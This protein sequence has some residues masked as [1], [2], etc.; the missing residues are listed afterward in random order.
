MSPSRPFILRPVATSLL[1]AGILLVGA[2]A[3]RQLPVSALPQVDYP[4]IQVVTFYP[5]ASPDVMASSVTAPLERQFGQVPG[6]N[7]MTSTSSSGASVITL[8][9]TLDLNID[10]AEQQVQAAINAAGTFLP[11]DLPNPPIYSKTNPADAPILTLALTSS[12]MPL[13][14]V[15]DLADTRLAQKIS[16]LSGVGLVSIS[17][18]QKPAVRIQANPMTLSS[19]KLNLEDLRLAIA[20]ANVNQ[21]K[22]N[23]DGP[24]NSY[25][26]GA[27]D[28]LLSSD[29]YRPLLIA[30]RNGAPVTLSDVATVI[31]SAENIKQAAWMNDAPAVILNIQ[32]QPGANIIEVVD[33]VKRLLPQLRASLPSS[34]DVATLTDRT[35]TIRASV[36]DVQFELMLTVALVVMVIFLFLR[37]LSAT[38]IPSVAVPL[39]LVGTFGAMYLLGYSLNN[40]TLMALTISTGFVVDDA[41]VMIENIARFIEA[42][43][44]PLQA[45][46]KGAEQIGF[47]ILSL[48]VSLIAVLIPLLFMGDIVGRLF[49][50]F[51]ITLSVTIL[52]SAAVSLTLTPMMCARL[53]HHKPESEQGRFY[54]ASEHMFQRIIAFYGRTLQVVLRHQPITLLVAVATLAATFLLY[55][56]IPKGFFPVQDTGVIL[57]V[58][59]APQTVS[60]AAM[61]QRQQS[62]AKMILQDPAVESLSSF[63]GID[64]TNTTVNSGRLQINLKPLEERKIS[65]SDVIRR[66]QPQL[67]KVDG[68]QLFM[69]PV[70][71][72]TVEDRVSRTQFQFSLEDPDPKE[73]DTW[74]PRFISKLQTLP[75]LRDVA[76]D[77]QNGGLQ[78]LLVIDRDT[79]SRFGITPQMIDDTLYDAFGQRQVSIMFT[80][81]NQYRV[82][83]EIKPDFQRNPDELKNIYIRSAQGGEVPLSAFTHF[84]PSNGPLVVNH[85]GQFPVVTASF[86]LASSASLGDAV[87]AV[88]KA[89]KELGLPASIATSFQGTAAAFQ[90]SLAN[91]PILILAAVITVYIVLGVLYESYIHPLTILSTLP[92]AGVGALL[93]LMLCR[94]DFSVIALIGIILLIGIVEKNAIMMIDFALDLERKEGYRP[95]DA[96]FQACLLRF[97]P[98]IMTTL[99]AMLGGV[100]LALGTGVGAELRRPL[101]IAIV[102]GLIFS[103]LLTLYTTPVIYLAFDRMARRV[104]GHRA[105]GS[106]LPVEET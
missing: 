5:G 17:G 66:L 14:K 37:T 24:L 98:I 34:I 18:G 50:E 86:N 90:A 31:D 88:N 51:A 65:A 45:A 33:R 76:S 67:A 92:S 39:S 52:I 35:I 44:P 16:Q 54:R 72:L 2:V 13:S 91:E 57:G 78:A 27:N 49:R 38:V 41:I 28:Q 87:D 32:R 71:D 1:M 69:Q 58:S 81:L 59:E 82:V 11:R 42:G 10:V 60:F 96:I 30:Y 23:F 48:T 53:L 80:Q 79:A 3:Y 106:D 94:Q 100:P 93:A 20:A 89:K 63:I 105:S 104:T 62:L 40:L 61:G 46:L 21:A 55:T 36:E 43:D 95:L 22:G 85:Q 75:H 73:L 102:G 25:T 47:T 6:L 56:I 26:I 97:R 19:Y 9:F 101:G 64:G 15:E 74:V 84:E 83:L 77:Q 68:I 103:Q 8:Q 4:T 12:T 7:Q 99:A 29:Q 70:Q